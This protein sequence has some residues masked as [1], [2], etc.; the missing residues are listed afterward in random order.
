MEN[1]NLTIYVASSVGIDYYHY[2]QKTIS[3]SGVNVKGISL[4]SESDYRRQAK[5]SGVAKILLRFQMYVFYPIL[6]LLKGVTCAPSSVFVVSSNT[7]YAPYLVRNLLRYRGIRVVHMLYD[8][9]P[10]ALEIAGG[11]SCHSFISKSIGLIAKS[12]QLGCDATVYLG[13]YLKLH[14]ESRWGPA[15]RSDVIDISTDLSLYPSTYNPLPITGP[16]II[17]YGGQLGHLH[18]AQ[19]IIT[20][21]RR[22]HHMK[23]GDSVKFIFYTSGAQADTLRKSLARYSIEIVSTAPSSQWRLDIQ[24]FHIGLVSLSP[25]GATVCLPSK[26]YALM[27]GGLAILS[28]APAWSDL[29]TLVSSLDAGWIVNNSL[30]HSTPNMSDP[31]YLDHVRK[32]APQDQIAEQFC[33]TIRS[34]LNN[35]SLLEE[36]RRNAFFGVRL[37]YGIESLSRKWGMLLNDLDKKSPS[38]SYIP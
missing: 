16:I 6:L 17:H 13:N 4:V 10:D 2:L 30:Y 28:I 15:L 33:Q 25:G 34:I 9:Y 31:F 14:A 36:K 18:D 11:L 29:A 37:R 27:A 3:L 35:R 7:F 22:I 21:V 20:C 23:L 5:S 8:L 24:R 32:M 1:T 12:N 26:T 19:S 38:S